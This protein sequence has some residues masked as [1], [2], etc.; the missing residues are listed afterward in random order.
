[1][2]TLG[3]MQEGVELAEQLVAELKSKDFTESQIA[4]LL[5]GTSMR[6]LLASNDL[7][8]AEKLAL[9]SVSRNAEIRRENIAEREACEVLFPKHK[10]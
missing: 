2:A 9:E 4:G 6:V 7:D 3:Q 10:P 8:N 5:I 1:M